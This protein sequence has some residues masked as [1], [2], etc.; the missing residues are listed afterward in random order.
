MLVGSVSWSGN[1][2]I[3]F[4]PKGD[5]SI[6]QEELDIAK[7]V[8]AWMQKNGGAIYGCQSAG[9]EEPK[10]GCYTMNAKTG[11]VCLV[12]FNTLQNRVL[13]VKLTKGT[14]VVGA[15]MLFLAKVLRVEEISSLQYDLHLG[16]VKLPND[17][18]VIEIELVQGKGEATKS[19]VA[20]K[21]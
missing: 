16:A 8:G 19:Y 15:K 10:W 2:M 17:P 20:P 5:G 6:R 7:N 9:L 14:R 11:K 1:V 12:V 3:N 13:R 18:Y 4:G 21:V